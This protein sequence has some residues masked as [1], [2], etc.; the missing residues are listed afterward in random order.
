MTEQVIGGLPKITTDIS[1]RSDQNL[2]TTRID[3]NMVLPFLSFLVMSTEYNFTTEV[4]TM[5]AT[6]H[7]GNKIYVNEEFLNSMTRRERA[8]VIAHEMLHIFLEH[9]GRQ[10]DHNYS[11]KLW[12]VATDYCINSHL[13]ELNE[14]RIVMPTFGLY[15]VRYKSMSADQIYHILLKDSDGDANAAESK[16]GNCG[17]PNSPFDE[18]NKRPITDGELTNNRQKIAAAICTSDISALKSKGMGYSDLIRMFE[19]LLDSKIPWQ[20]VLREYIIQ[21]S[22]T[23][24]T[25]N[26][27]SRKS[28][29]S[30]VIFPTMTGDNINLVFGVDTSGSMSSADLTE[31][32]TELHS[33]CEE[34]DNWVVD[35]VSCDTR[36]HLIGDYNSE[37]GD[38]FC[39]VDINL[40]GGG[41]TEM[42]P[43]VEYA[44]DKEDEP[45][46]CIIITDGYIPENE[47]DDMVD[48]I[49]TIVIVT[50]SGNKDLTLTKC[51]VL[52]MTESEAA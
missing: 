33:I 5:A 29:H 24:Y 4:K 45:S 44:N 30:K 31:A 15:D 27:P 3:L 22:K 26:R 18:L 11:G 48:E 51:E 2:K 10:T 49:P 37:D 9:I 8:F 42:S 28:Y 21:S 39:S 38:D 47:L 19:D 52:F 14:S 16:F 6:T 43:M 32:L 13:I 17:E 36:V 23:R 50:S 12:N 7:G 41:G 1:A 35:L 34:F 40:V 20:S 25:Y 46:V